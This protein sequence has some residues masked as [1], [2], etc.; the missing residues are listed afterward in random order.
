MS[1]LAEQIDEAPRRPALRWHGGKWRLAPWIIAQFPPHYAYVEPFGGGASV[2]LRKPRSYSEVHNDLDDDVVGLFRVLQDPMQ[3]VRLK[4][5]LD[6]TPYARRELELAYEPTSDAVERARRLIVRGAMGFG[7][8]AHVSTHRGH[9]TTGFRVTAHRARNTTPATDW[10]NYPASIDAVVARFRSVVIE[11]R[12]AAEVMSMHDGPDTLFYLDPP[13]QHELRSLGN[14]YD[15]QLR[16]Y[17]HEL[18]AGAHAAL[19]AFIRGLKGMVLL[20][21]YPSALYDE[22]LPG[23]LRLEQAARIDGGGHRTEVLWMNLAAAARRRAEAL[24]LF[25]DTPSTHEV[26][27]A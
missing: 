19:L 22:G 8:N 16:F 7:S 2:L 24:P 9:R 23:W 25:R 6:L 13:Y 12:D 4:T 20:S 10:A 18:D 14:R 27:S 17:R 21:G 1:L 3:S 11:H 5:L 15:L 26:E